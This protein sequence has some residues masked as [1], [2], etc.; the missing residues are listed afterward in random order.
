MISSFGSVTASLPLIYYL[1]TAESLILA[2]VA[3]PICILS[4]VRRIID[5]GFC[6]LHY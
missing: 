5:F 6:P 3:A 4:V 1:F 2:S